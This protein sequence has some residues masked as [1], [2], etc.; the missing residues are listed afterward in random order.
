MTIPPPRHRIQT[1]V[2]HF[3]RQRER[4]PTEESL[5]P[6]TYAR[7]RK[8]RIRSRMG[9]RDTLSSTGKVVTEPAQIRS[10]KNYEKVS[11]WVECCKKAG[12]FYGIK[13]FLAIKKG[14]PVYNKAKEY[15]GQ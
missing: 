11:Y 15:Y 10:K 4:F 3:H 6:V 8:Y 12:S 2:F 7:K 9:D 5:P 14:T 13:G 1:H